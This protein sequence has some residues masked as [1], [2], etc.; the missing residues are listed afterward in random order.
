MLLA[1]CLALCGCRG[2]EQ[3]E[4][5][6]TPPAEVA[7]APSE[8]PAVPDAPVVIEAYY[9]L[10][11][12]HQFIADYVLAIGEANPDTVQVTVY[13]MQS[14]E[15]RKKWMTSGLSCAGIFVNGSTEHRIKRGDETETVNLLR[16][17]DVTWTRDD[18]LTCC[19]SSSKSWTKW[20]QPLH[21][22]R[23]LPRRERRLLNR[24]LGLRVSGLI[25]ACLLLAGCGGE[26]PEVASP[27]PVALTVYVPCV[28]SGPVLQIVSAYQ[29][30]HPGVEV[31]ALVEKPMAMLSKVPGAQGGAAV[32]IT[33]G[34]LEMQSL[35]ADGVVAP[36]D[37]E[38]IALNTY[39]IVLLAAAD[40]VPGVEGLEDV[41]A[42]DVARIYVEDPSKSSLGDRTEQSLRQLGLWEIAAPKVVHPQADAMLLG[43]LVAGEADLAFVFQGCWSDE[44]GGESTVP[45]T[46]RLIG[47]LPPDTYRP[48]EYKAAPLS[49]AVEAGPAREF[50][51][52][53]LSPEGREALS[54]AG[55]KPTQSQ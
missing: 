41:A 37:V 22:R 31:Q 29:S 52:F 48:I 51:D 12:S 18:L 54:E 23:K 30:T 4:P 15:G 49:G 38:T 53:L 33:T 34:E 13:D 40:G 42:P 27:Q 24:T 7:G 2:G 17:M 28:L 11:P 16:R 43:G 10:N 1:C 3:P 44:S 46:L 50:V 32:A 5:E 19:W 25:A 55:L 20:E 45:K 14:P 21:H 26:P 8:T 47:E 9:P 39:G 36:S 6:S 35:I